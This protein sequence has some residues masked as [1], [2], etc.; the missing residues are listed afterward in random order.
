[1]KNF[2]ILFCLLLS[3]ISQSL[4][5]D[6]LDDAFHAYK[7]R[8]YYSSANLLLRSTIDFQSLSALNKLK[9]GIIFWNNAKINQ[10]I[11]Q[12]SLK[13]RQIYLESLITDQKKAKSEFIY[14]YLG[15]IYLQQNEFKNARKN[16]QTFIHLSD[17]KISETYKNLA[18]IYLAWIKLKEKNVNSFLRLTEP[19]KGKHIITDMAIAYILESEGHGNLVDK[20]IQTQITS[21]FI[22]KNNELTSRAGNYALSILLA[23]NKLESARAIYDRIQLNAPSYVEEVT[24][25]KTIN[26]YEVTLPRTMENF[27]STY[28][29]SLFNDVKKDQRLSDTATFYLSEM[30]IYHRD[31]STAQQFE[32]AVI[33]LHRL[34]KNLIPLRNI[35][36][37]AHGFLDGQL[38][39]T[40]Q[41]WKE[42]VYNDKND[43]LLINDAILMCF[44]LNG[45]CP[46]LFLKAQTSAEDSRSRRFT[47]LSTTVGRYFL[48]KNIDDKAL[49][50][51]EIALDH[52]NMNSLLANDPILLINLAEAYRVNKKF[53]KSLQV[54]FSLGQ[55]FPTMRQVLD[56]VQGEYLFQQR[57]SGQTNVF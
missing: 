7:Q 38:T 18:Q 12:K 39:R 40:Y 20:N 50:L 42:A 55:N 48:S 6:T 25:L 1:M 56:A 37:S 22:A 49:R 28:A 2:H 16:F 13:T 23:N 14:F 5:A 21:S 30:A 46:T 11:F 51:L 35:R 45:N 41:V 17:P 29:A 10:E 54:Y 36:A 31:K 34:S 8:Q 44:I 52:N 27:Y 19:Y 26:F 15:K 33:N 3:L 4:L 32:K 9:A 47:E 24:R 43:P 57:S 53:S